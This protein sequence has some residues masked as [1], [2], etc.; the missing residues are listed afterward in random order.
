[1]KLFQDGNTIPFIARYRRD[2][3]E[4]MGPEKLREVKDSFDEICHLKQK[5]QSVIKTLD[6][7]GVLNE[8][9]ESTVRCTKSL[10]EL[11]IIVRIYIFIGKY[12]FKNN[13]LIHVIYSFF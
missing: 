10:D 9:L 7:Q 12:L 3:T 4:N 5:I 13:H 6:K 11:E 2:I 8:Q 1:M